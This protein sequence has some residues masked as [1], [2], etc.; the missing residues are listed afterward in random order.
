MLSH[1]R[2]QKAY[3]HHASLNNE[4]ARQ[5]LVPINGEKLGSA[6]EYWMRSRLYLQ[7]GRIEE[8]KADFQQANALG[9]N[10]SLLA[11]KE[12]LPPDYHSK[13][14]PKFEDDFQVQR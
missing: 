4:S 7:L 13:P 8:A 11:N 1:T 14:P 2:L 12:N 10:P 6:V 3:I 5:L 9:L